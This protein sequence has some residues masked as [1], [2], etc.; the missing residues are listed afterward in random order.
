LNLQNIKDDAEQRIMENAECIMGEQQLRERHLTILEGL[1]GD[2]T[3][4]LGARAIVLFA[5]GSGRGR[6]SS[7]NQFVA[8][9]L[10]KKRIAT[11]LVDLLNQEEKKTDEKTK[12]LRYDIELLARRFTAVTNWVAQ[13]PDIKDLAIGYFGSST[14]AAAAIIAAERLVAAK[15]IVT[16]GGHPDLAS[17]II[18][19]QVK[20]PTLFIVGG[21]DTPVVTMNKR[22]LESL[23]N[24]EAK[25]LAIIPAATHLFDGPTDMEEVAEVAADWFEYHLLRRGKKKFHNRDTGITRSGFL[26]S[27]WNKYAFQIKFK[28]RFAAGQILASALGK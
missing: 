1:E 24:A 22:A 12:H 28:D 15:A 5:H 26:S 4:P 25:E 17:E 23:T 27:L 11:L 8:N 6:Y 21:N 13:Q 20:A 16:R 18:L 19:N 3:I 2:L 14:G 9:V 10:N 7:R